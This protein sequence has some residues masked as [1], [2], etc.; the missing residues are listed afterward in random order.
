MTGRFRRGGLAA[1]MLLALGTAA[2]PVARAQDWFANS[3]DGYREAFV[4]GEQD[5]LFNIAC[6]VERPERL[7]GFFF[8][9]EAP[10][11]GQV[12][13]A[14]SVTL[15]IGQRRDRYLLRLSTTGLDFEAGDAASFAALQATLEALM[16]GQRLTVEA[17]ELGWREDFLLGGAADVLAG[18]LAGCER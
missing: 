12:G 17:L 8:W 18:L 3:G 1:A 4:Y 6:G 5:T 16:A 15:Q 11:A 10:L 13:S 2:G 14:Y 7:A 9:L